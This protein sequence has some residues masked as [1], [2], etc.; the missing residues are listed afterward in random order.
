MED[1]TSASRHYNWKFTINNWTP[2]HVQHLKAMKY[3]YLLFGREVGK[4]GTP[5]LQGVVRM[6]SNK[7]FTQM[8]T[9]NM[10]PGAHLEVVRSMEDAIE[11]C[12]KDGD[13]EEYGSIPITKKE[14]GQME[15]DRWVLALHQARTTG[16]VEDAQI[17]FVHARNINYIYDQELRKRQLVDTEAEHEWYWGASGTGKS[18]TARS[19]YPDAYLKMCNRWWDG[20]VNEEFVIIEDFDG[21]HDGLCHHMKIWSDRYPFNAEKK[22]SVIKIRP[23]KIIVTS[24]YHPSS[25]WTTQEDLEPILRRFKVT[26]F[27][28]LEG[29]KFVPP[30]PPPFTPPV[31]TTTTLQSLDDDDESTLILPSLPEDDEDLITPAQQDDDDE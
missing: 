18:Y 30:P 20:Y 22:G 31:T 25:I 23:K 8:K 12:K 28:L 10:V 26:E 7:T 13:Y 2:E 19:K 1:T 11:Y 3:K 29:Q 14:Q 24:N 16:Q 5:H 6:K 9:C 27:K 17:A 15:K 4:E 21:G